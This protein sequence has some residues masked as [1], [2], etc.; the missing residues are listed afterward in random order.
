MHDDFG[1]QVQLVEFVGDQIAACVIPGAFADPVARWG[2]DP[3]V[4]GIDGDS[5][6]VLDYLDNC[7]TDAN[8]SQGDTDGDDYGN[9]CDG[10]FDNNGIVD[11][12]DFN[13]FF[14]PQFNRGRLEYLIRKRR[15]ANRARESIRI[16]ADDRK[17][18]NW[19]RAR[20]D[21]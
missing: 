4:S 6:G 19:N 9:R 17:G 3:I 16:K 8:P 21:Q 7:S 20:H 11:S 15:S 5:D 13:E 10:D 14:I 12:N 2:E 18:V 1:A